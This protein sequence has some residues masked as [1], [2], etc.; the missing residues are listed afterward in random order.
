MIAHGSGPFPARSRR[1]LRARLTPHIGA[2]CRSLSLGGPVGIRPVEYGTHHLVW[3]VTTRS[4]VYAFR[5]AAATS[6]QTAAVRRRREA[7]WRH[8][9]QGGIGPGF[10]GSLRIKDPHFD[11][12]LEAFGWLPGRHLNPSRDT[13]AVAE[14]LARLHALPLPTKP[15]AAPRVDLPELLRQRL[16]YYSL[17]TAS[18]RLSAVLRQAADTARARLHEAG[19]LRA[20][21]ALVHNDLVAANVLVGPQRA[22]LIDWDWA[23][24]S[25]PTVDLFCFLS[26]FVRSWGDRPRFLSPRSVR[27]FLTAYAAGR[28]EDRVRQLINEGLAY[29]VPY[30]VV[31]ALWL[32]VDAPSRPH[33]RRASFQTRA[34]A[35]CEAIGALLAGFKPGATGDDAALGEPDFSLRVR[36]KKG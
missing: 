14:C 1:A 11:G 2:A 16:D 20:R 24:I 6:R 29:W 22:W 4:G 10:H 8:V 34:L 36:R 23:L 19:P 30:N 32:A 18:G 31:I 35:E 5:A 25:Q 26:P 12:W 33:T 7:L 3:R 13:V 28:G 27:A 21:P 15:I 17:H 9:A